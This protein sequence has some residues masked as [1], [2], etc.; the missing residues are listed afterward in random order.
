M[1]LPGIKLNTTPTDYCPIEAMRL[2]KFNGEI[3]QLFG[4]R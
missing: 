1:M 2:Q 3:W 4:T